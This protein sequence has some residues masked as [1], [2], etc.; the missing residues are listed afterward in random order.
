MT[1]SPL[2]AGRHPKTIP[3][4]PKDRD[5]ATLVV[6]DMAAFKQSIL[7]RQSLQVKDL[8][9]RTGHLVSPKEVDCDSLYPGEMFLRATDYLSDRQR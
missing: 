4:R 8:P 1:P 9:K 5:G 2:K 6:E 7:A 3:V